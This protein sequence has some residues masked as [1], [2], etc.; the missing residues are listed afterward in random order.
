[1]K[2]NSSFIKNILPH[3]VSCIM[4]FSITAKRCVRLA[5]MNF[6]TRARPHCQYI[7]ERFKFHYF[8]SIPA[9]HETQNHNNEYSL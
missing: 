8:Q 1:M 6:Q 2:K 9:F 5:G 4:L 3:N 7:L